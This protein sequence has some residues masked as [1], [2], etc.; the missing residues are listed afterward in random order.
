MFLFFFNF[1]IKTY[2]NYICICNNFFLIF[3]NAIRPDKYMF[4]TFDLLCDNDCQWQV[5]GFSPG[6]P[7]S[8]TNKTDRHDITEIL[9]KVA[10]NTITLTPL[11]YSR[12]YFQ[13]H[14]PKLYYTGPTSTVMWIVLSFLECQKYIKCISM[15][16]VRKYILFVTHVIFHL[17][18]LSSL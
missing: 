1:I 16:N 13:I 7:V 12:V 6:T 9:L 18:Y 11:M 15:T 3:G 5:G 14:I 4:P 10:L 17:L 8:C 2:G